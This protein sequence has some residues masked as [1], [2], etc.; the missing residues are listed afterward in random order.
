[1]NHATCRAEAPSEGGPRLLRPARHFDRPS[2][3]D[4]RFRTSPAN[5]IGRD[6]GNRVAVLETR[7]TRRTIHR[8]FE[9]RA[10][11]TVFH[12]SGR[13][14]LLFQGPLLNGQVYL[15]EIVDTGGFAGF[16]CVMKEG[17]N[18]DSG[19]QSHDAG[20]NHNFY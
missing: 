12:G 13:P 18:G 1:M 8:A 3:P 9:V 20:Y 19:E 16:S 11:V 4:V 2:H 15:P 5:R 7:A 14:F 6:R 10:D 17:R